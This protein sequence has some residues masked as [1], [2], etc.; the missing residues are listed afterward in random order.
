MQFDINLFQF[1][2]DLP[3]AIENGWTNFMV[4]DLQAYQ[5][6]LEEQGMEQ[7]DM[8]DIFNAAKQAVKFVEAI[9]GSTEDELISANFQNGL[10][11]KVYGPCF[12]QSDEEDGFKLRVGTKFYD[13]KLTNEK[14]TVGKLKGQISVSNRKGADN[15]DSISKKTGNPIL[16]VVATLMITGDRSADAP[17]FYIPLMLDI[18]KPLAAPQVMGAIEDSNIHELMAKAPKGN[19]KFVDLRMLP[20]HDFLV[21]DISDP[22]YGDYNGKE[23]ISWNM[24]IPDVGIVSTRGKALDREF[25]QSWKLYQKFARNKGIT[26]RITKH[27]VEY[28]TSTGEEKTVPFPNFIIDLERDLVK[29]LNRGSGKIGNSNVKHHI[30]AGIKTQLQVPV[31][32][33]AIEKVGYVMNMINP[34]NESQTKILPAADDAIEAEV[35]YDDI[36]F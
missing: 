20:V 18:E 35:T 19:G 32:E 6:Y 33:F 10:L 9:G 3:K 36:P 29:D 4:S 11:T 16:D 8:P 28:K 22:K 5:T 24:T 7:E 15:K 13:A 23:I 31:S 30:D 2:S 21:T 12:W 1:V 17:V 34:T 26:L 14:I 27:D 25:E